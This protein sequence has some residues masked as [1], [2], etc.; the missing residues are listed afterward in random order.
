MGYKRKQERV[1]DPVDGN[2]IGINEIISY[3]FI[4]GTFIAVPPGK[5]TGVGDKLTTENP[6]PMFEE[7]K[8]W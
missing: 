4:T 6:E 2:Y 7:S 1:K 5:L 8:G 3:R